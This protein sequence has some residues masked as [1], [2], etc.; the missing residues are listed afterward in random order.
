MNKYVRNR[1]MLH[2]VL[3]IVAATIST[4]PLQAQDLRCLGSCG[5]PSQ[6]NSPYCSQRRIDCNNPSRTHP[7]PSQ[8]QFYGAIAY[9]LSANK[10][11]YSH[12]YRTAEQ[13]ERRAVYECLRKT[14]GA[15][16][17]KSEVSFFNGC[18][19][20]A[21]GDDDVVRWGRHKNKPVAEESALSSCRRNNGVNCELI[22]SHCSPCDASDVAAGTC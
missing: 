10:V 21:F 8:T 18:G 22:F 17:C 2:V 15:R 12:D 16:D 5:I 14:G 13:A 20:L 4:P 7:S 11:G 1:R 9:S 19:A 6:A 3:G